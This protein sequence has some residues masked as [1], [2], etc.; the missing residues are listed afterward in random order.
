MT[1]DSK[2]DK[3]Y[4]QAVAEIDNKIRQWAGELKKDIKE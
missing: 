2:I 3:M 4:I 1:V